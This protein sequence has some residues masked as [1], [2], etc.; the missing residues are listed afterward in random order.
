MVFFYILKVI[1]LVPNQTDN[2][3]YIQQQHERKRFIFA[4]K[5][6]TLRRGDA[7]KNIYTMKISCQNGRFSINFFSP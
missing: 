1:K 7:R 6:S 3:H 4:E 5:S 2:G